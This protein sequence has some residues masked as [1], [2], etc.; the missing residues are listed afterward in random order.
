MN[1]V[2]LIYNPQAGKKRQI[3]PGQKQI[4]LEDIKDLLAQYQIE[5]DYYPTK[6]PEDAQRLAKQSQKQGYELVIAAGG[7]GTV[8]EVA[9]GLI[10]SE[11]RLGILPLGTFMNLARMLAIPRDLEQ[12]IQIIKIGRTRKIDVGKINHNYFFEEAGIG[13]EAE[14]HHLLTGIFER[15]ERT[16]FFKLF[17]LLFNFYGYSAKLILDDQTI[18]TKATLITISNGPYGGA[19]L[20]LAPSAKLN[21]HCLT[22]TL[23]TMSK[24]GIIGYLLGLLIKGRSS[25]HKKAVY[26]SQKV[27]IETEVKRLIHADARVFGE[28]PA[29]FETIPNA[30]NVICGFPK[31]G[32]SSLKKRTILDA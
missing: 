1:K 25:S 15:G 23:L 4:T 22:V 29:H 19:A 32:Q 16:N 24:L 30:L 20:K 9:I 31:D 6:G 8:S 5:A 14:A 3:I 26:K 10:G 2:K 18:E 13:I 17:K 28:T 21:D 11:V 27:M 7:D 12:A